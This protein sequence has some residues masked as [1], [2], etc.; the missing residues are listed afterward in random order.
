MT[1]KD[2]LGLAQCL[3]N[4]GRMGGG[5]SCEAEKPSHEGSL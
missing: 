4:P 5:V 3:P 2:I 1:G